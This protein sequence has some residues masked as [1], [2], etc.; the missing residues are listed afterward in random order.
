M[1]QNTDF[2]AS[3]NILDSNSNPVDLS[4]LT[5]ESQMRHQYGANSAYTFSCNGYSN[6]YLTIQ[7]PANTTIM[8]ASSYVY[9]I[10]IKDNSNTIVRLI[11]GVVKVT[12][13]V[14]TFQ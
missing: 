13:G 1:L 8:N 3:F 5:V 2:L 4:S 10:Y 6:G 12:P 7:L 14:T 11:E 9:D